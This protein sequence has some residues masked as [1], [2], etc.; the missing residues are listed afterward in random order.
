MKN[1]FIFFC[2]ISFSFITS[3]TYDALIKG[4]SEKIYTKKES[5]QIVYLIKK[6]SINSE[7][8]EVINFYGKII[9]QKNNEI[10]GE[11]DDGEKS[12]YF[13]HD[14]ISNYY[15]IFQ[16]PINFKICGFKVS[17]NFEENNNILNSYLSLPFLNE[18]KFNIKIYNKEHTTQ[19]ISIKISKSMIKE[20]DAVYLEENGIKFIPIRKSNEKYIFYYALIKNKLTLD[21]TLKDSNEK[22]ESIHYADIYL[23]YETI[24]NIS[25][26]ATKCLD[27]ENLKFY[28]IK[29]KDNSKNN[30]E[31][32]IINN[33]KLY[34]IESNTKIGQIKSNVTYKNADTGILMLDSFENNGCFSVNFSN[35]N[36]NEKE[37]NIINN[38]VKD[39][40]SFYYKPILLSY[41][42][43]EPDYEEQNI[44]NDYFE[45]VKTSKKFYLIPNS[46]K[47]FIRLTTNT[48]YSLYFKIEDVYP[49]YVN[50]FELSK[51]KYVIVKGSS[52]KPI[53]INVLY[54]KNEKLEIVLNKKMIYNVVAYTET[55][56]FDLN[57]V[58]N[59]DYVITYTAKS[60]KNN[61]QFKGG[62]YSNYYDSKEVDF[63]PKTKKEIKCETYQSNSDEYGI[64]EFYFYIEQY[65][66]HYTLY[67][68]AIILSI[69]GFFFIFIVLCKACGHDQF[70]VD[71]DALDDAFERIVLVF[72]P[73]KI[74]NKVKR[75]YK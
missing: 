19:L 70:F 50:N 28:K 66:Y 20:I 6:N 46:Q 73:R 30:Y 74:H 23:N 8:F 12:F 64:I 13:K 43:E 54:L 22:K 48:T 38:K 15:M 17:N 4:N 71:C 33:S 55:F 60:I 49:D 59:I 7:F 18:R 14:G 61:V 69:L 26:N 75:K 68:T 58:K 2:I 63:D 57:D 52:S 39:M 65:R 1:I 36:V 10:I 21:I 16:F 3:M 11:L 56:E 35:E 42:E 41:S 25:N 44:E 45:I 29:S 27:N 72:C 34:L 9:I 31:L 37:N 40:K 24:E 53:T 47:K 67:W 51:K 62:Y 5:S 32:S